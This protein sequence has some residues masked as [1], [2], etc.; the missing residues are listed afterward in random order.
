MAT[1]SGSF[2]SVI[3]EFT[4]AGHVERRWLLDEVTGALA[5]RSRR[6]VLV[7]GVP[8]TG[9]T[10]LAS[11]LIDEN[12]DWLR[13]FV[14]RDDGGAHAHPNLTEFLKSIGH[15]FARRYPQAFDVQ[16]LDVI[17]RQW[18]GTVETDATVIAAKIGK[19]VVSPF[20]STAAKVAEQRMV[21]EQHA[22]HVAGNV[23]GVEIGSM[24]LDPDLMDAQ[25][26]A[27]VALI[28]PAQVLLESDPSA[29]IVIVFDGLDIAARARIQAGDEDDTAGRLHA[30]LGGISLPPNVQ[31]VLTSRPDPSLEMI[32]TLQRDRLTVI[33]L[34]TEDART[35]A[36]L[37]AYAASAIPA[38][39]VEA[40]GMLTDDF[41]RR[42]ARH[43][44]GNFQYLATYARALDDAARTTGEAW[45]TCTTCTRP[46]PAGPGVRWPAGSA[47]SGPRSS[48]RS[49]P[50]A[51][52]PT[53]TTRRCAC[54]SGPSTKRS[55]C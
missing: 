43:A 54:R 31:L 16:R 7:T 53:N 46:P 49:T 1:G 24:E 23:T 15:Q 12:E 33:T 48:A 32:R 25:T 22:E 38:E 45:R 11:K 39:R 50:I 44:H 42:L 10:S 26:L 8:G 35:T 14:G 36:D 41:Y 17:V 47:A 20:V 37:A 18:F 4:G 28:A 9:K 13:Y 3:R 27:Q 19:L 5:D 6:F 21:V 40:S 34:D 30:W 55:D 29:R 52:P 2:E 51:S